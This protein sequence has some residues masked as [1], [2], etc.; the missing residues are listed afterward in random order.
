[1][2][3]KRFF[4]A[5]I[6]IAAFILS[7]IPFNFAY[8]EANGQAELPG[9]VQNFLA[10]SRWKNWEVTAWANPR[11]Q[12]SDSACAFAVVKNGSSNTLV[13]FGWNGKW[14]YKWSNPS[15]LPQVDEPVVLGEILRDSINFTSFYVYNNEIQEMFCVWEQK[16]NGSWE[17]QELQHFGC[18]R[19]QKG[20]MFFDTS[21]DGVLKMTNEGWVQ[22]QVTNTQVY[23]EYQ[24]NLRYFNLSAFPLT[25]SEAREKLSSPPQIPAGTLQANKVKFPQGRKY[26]VYQGPGEEYGRSGSGKASV[27]T[28]DWLQVFGKENGWLMIQYDITADH[29]RI[30]WIKPDKIPQSANI[31]PLNFNRLKTATAVQSELNDD[32]LFSRSKVSS[33]PA[34]TSVDVLA[35]MGEWAYVEAPNYANPVRG[36]ILQ[37]NLNM[38]QL[39]PSYNTQTYFVNNP[40]PADRLHLRTKPDAKSKSLGKY[41]NGVAVTA[42]SQIKN[43]WLHVNIG[44]LTGYMDA[45]FLSSAAPVSSI[46]FLPIR[47]ERGTGLNLRTQQTTNSPSLGLYLNNVTVQILGLTDTWCH[48]KT[49]DGKTGFMLLSGFEKEIQYDLYKDA[50]PSAYATIKSACSLYKNTN[51]TEEDIITTLYPPCMVKV[52]NKGAAWTKVQFNDNIGYVETAA[53]YFPQ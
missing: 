51:P 33:L 2:K 21:N 37:T 35:F 32:P 53:L 44:S 52:I 7:A 22:G 9:E 38:A 5:L 26:A 1:M 25:L 23:G 24:K 16:P 29:M 36:F 4:S 20:L 13:A 41:Y 42:L 31:Y 6:L 15:A 3:N 46:P 14:V 48:V 34:N 11:R 8:G 10:E 30:G 47:N 43:G 12:K 19:P 49:M 17:L 40:N 45:R 50:D 39:P 28:N 18:Y 27:S